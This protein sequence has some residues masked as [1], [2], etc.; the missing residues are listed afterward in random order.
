MVSYIG[1]SDQHTT[2]TRMTKCVLLGA[3]TIPDTRVLKAPCVSVK[4]SARLNFR[5]RLSARVDMAPHPSGKHAIPIC[6]GGITCLGRSHAVARAESRRPGLACRWSPTSVD[7]RLNIQIRNSLQVGWDV[8]VAHIEPIVIQ[9]NLNMIHWTFEYL[10]RW[11][12]QQGVSEVFVRVVGI[13]H[14]G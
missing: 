11:W 7:G 13:S 9:I 10:C 14:R 1:V 6:I 3:Y 12:P 8:F 5:T 2:L 4:C